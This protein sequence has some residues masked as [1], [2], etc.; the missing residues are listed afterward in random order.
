MLIIFFDIKGIFHKEF[1]LEGQTVNSAHYCN[2][3]RRMREN[4]RRLHLEL[5][6]QNKSLLHHNAPS[7]TSFLTR[8]YFTKNN[9]TV[10]PH[11]PYFSVSPD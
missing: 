7:H 8:K 5:W 11:Q 3:L 9:M 1:V 10:V 4:V 2:V 6:R